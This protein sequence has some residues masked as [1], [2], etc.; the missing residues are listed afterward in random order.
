MA[1]GMGHGKHMSTEKAKDF[2]TQSMEKLLDGICPEQVDEEYMIVLL[3]TP[4]KGQLERQTELTELY[5]K[6]APYAQWQTNYTYTE[7]DNEGSHATVGVNLGATAGRRSAKEEL[8]T[9]GDSQE[10]RTSDIERDR[11]F[12]YYSYSGFCR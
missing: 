10:N 11:R 7:M 3:A 9:Q 5:S 8:H 6:L 2:S 12:P 1:K 4:V